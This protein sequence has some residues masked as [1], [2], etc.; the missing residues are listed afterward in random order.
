MSIVHSPYSIHNNK[1]QT[2]NQT[3]IHCDA[4]QLMFCEAVFFLAR[5][6][7]VSNELGAGRPEIACY[8]ARVTFWPLAIEGSGR[9]TG[10]VLDLRA[11]SWRFFC[12]NVFSSSTVGRLWCQKDNPNSLQWGE[13]CTFE[14]LYI[15]NFAFLGICFGTDIYIFTV[16]YIV[17]LKIVS[18]TTIVAM[19]RSRER[20]VASN[21]TPKIYSSLFPS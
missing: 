9:K 18:L 7:R 12:S 16:T 13:L 8:A 2:S 21:R 6:T 17:I 11:M 19:H 15:D 10:E 3:H 20:L 14:F 1:Q 5:N 4:S